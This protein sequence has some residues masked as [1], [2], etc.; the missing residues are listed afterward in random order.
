V[1]GRIGGEDEGLAEIESNSV[2]RSEFFEA[3]EEP[4]EIGV[5]EKAGDVVNVAFGVSGQLVWL[6]ALVKLGIEW[7]EDTEESQGSE[8]AAERAAL[9]KTFSLVKE[10]EAIRC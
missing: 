5:S 10:V 1:I 7:D 3:G 2:G 6:T 4:G 9:G 8:E